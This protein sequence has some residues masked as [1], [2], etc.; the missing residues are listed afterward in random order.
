MKTAGAIVTDR[1][2]RT[3]HAAIVARELGVPAVVG[4]EARDRRR[5]RPAARSPCPAPKA[6]SA[7]SMTA[8]LPFEVTQLPA[9]ALQ[10]AAHRRS[11]SISAIPDLAFRT[12]MHAERR[13]RPRAHGVHHQRAY[14]RPSDGAGCTRRRSPRHER[15]RDRRARRATSTSPREFFVEHAGGGRRHDRRG[16]LSEAGDR[17]AVRLQDQRV[18]AAC[19]AAPAFEP[20]GREP[21]ARLP[22]RLALCASGLCR[23]LRAGMRGAAP[24]AR[25]HGADQS[26]RH[27][28]VLPPRRGGRAG[29]RGDGAQRTASAART[30]WRST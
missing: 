7:R 19:S 18:R 26:A 9:S 23:R 1:G 2:G 22:R 17:P 3:C 13:R 29:A 25:G 14:R 11:W 21:D 6:R 16:V 15:A 5:C 27:G 4:A 28:A 30:G 8:T 20:Q 10:R 12:A 24:R